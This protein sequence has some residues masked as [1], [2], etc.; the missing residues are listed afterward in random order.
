MDPIQALITAG[1]VGLR[2]YEGSKNRKAQATEA[3][4]EREH[5]EKMQREKYAGEESY[6]NRKSSSELLLED[7]RLK[8]NALIKQLEVEGNVQVAEVIRKQ[9]VQIAYMEQSSAD[10]RYISNIFLQFAAEGM[11]TLQ[12]RK[13]TSEDAGMAN[14]IGEKA[15]TDWLDRNPL[16]LQGATSARRFAEDRYIDTLTSGLSKE[17]TE[18]AISIT[19]TS[20]AN[21]EKL[22]PGFAKGW[23]QSL[24]ESYVSDKRE[25]IPRG[26]ILPSVTNRSISVP[27]AI[28]QSDQNQSFPSIPSLLG[29][30]E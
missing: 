22:Y 9:N 6:L 26:K 24:G 7:M 13:I 18:K 21:V 27:Q 23:A 3:T 28:Q 29:G 14:M 16:D 30:G 8:N 25:E 10:K 1:A 19:R 12:G 20:L 5:E 15:Y 11:T 2:L 17:D 4:A